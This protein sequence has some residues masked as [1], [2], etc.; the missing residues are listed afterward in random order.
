MIDLSYLITIPVFILGGII[1]ITSNYK[2]NYTPMGSD[3]LKNMTLLE[4]NQ[5]MISYLV[6]EYTKTVINTTVNLFSLLKTNS[7]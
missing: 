7:F 5:Y 3:T 2:I 4:E 1:L 6:R